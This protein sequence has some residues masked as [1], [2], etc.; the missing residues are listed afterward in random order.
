MGQVGSDTIVPADTTEEMQSRG[1]IQPQYPGGAKALK[2]FIQMNLKYPRE[3]YENRIEGRV[4]I[5][6]VV[7]E[8]GFVSDVEIVKSAHP[9]LDA[10]SLRVARLFKQWIPGTVN[11]E[12][13]KARYSMPI[14]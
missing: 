14:I 9:L 13:V 6:F 7:D 5:A 2:K 3:A 10:E 11:G 8:K 12:P 1:E 4:V